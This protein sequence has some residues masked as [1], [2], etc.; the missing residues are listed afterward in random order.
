MLYDS[1]DITLDRMINTGYASYRCRHRKTLNT[2]KSPVTD[3]TDF[4]W[5]VS[6]AGYCWYQAQPHQ[7]IEGSPLSR[8]ADNPKMQTQWVITG[9]LS[10]GLPTSLQLYSPLITETGLYRRFIEVDPYDRD[11]MLAFA[12]T[13]GLLGI[14]LRVDLR[15]GS[16]SIHMLGERE[17][18]WKE[19]IEI[20]RQAV[21]M[22]DMCS[23]NDA[24]ALSQLVHENGAGRWV[25]TVGDQTEVVEPFL[26]NPDLFMLGN[27]II[28]AGFVVQRWINDRL[29]QYTSPQVLYQMD[30][31]ERV[32]RIRPWSLLGAMWLQ[33]AL[34]IDCSRFHKSCKECSRW[35][36]VSTE[37]D[38]KRVNREF[39]SDRCKSKNYRR[40]KTEA[41]Q[42]KSQGKT[43][44]AIAKQLDTEPSTIKTWVSTG[45]G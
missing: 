3:V 4:F 8:D 7:G 2:E 21:A 26:P 6:P 22:W 13:Y 30:R 42:L 20:M 28:P 38:G 45:K 10:G 16:T 31:G 17:H 32:F 5:H 27:P 43:I 18:R 39:C 35:F 24:T 11:S 29:K 40:R 1:Y 25:V 19:E 23:N 33:F 36:E 34:T 41:I 15:H 44:A 12:N 37:G 14:G 9:N